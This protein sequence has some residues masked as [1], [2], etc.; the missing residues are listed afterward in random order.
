[1]K[2]NNNLTISITDRGAKVRTGNRDIATINFNRVSTILSNLYS[3]PDKNRNT[4]KLWQNAFKGVLNAQEAK[5]LFEAF[6]GE[7]GYLA[8]KSPRIMVWTSAANPSNWTSP[9]CENFFKKY[10]IKSVY[11]MTLG[12]DGKALHPKK[13]KSAMTDLVYNEVTGDFESPNQVATPK[14]VLI[15][16]CRE[17]VDIDK[18]PIWANLKDFSD[19][20]LLA[21]LQR[22]EDERKAAEELASKKALVA[23]FLEAYGLTME[24]LLSVAE[25]I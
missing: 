17:E 9:W 1:M 23:E 21:E 19:E 20:E 22:R 12:A 3:G 15:E 11:G 18:M 13:R 2:I 25:V 16:P 10:S 14:E 5:R 7:P 6:A 24:D 4:I 8:A